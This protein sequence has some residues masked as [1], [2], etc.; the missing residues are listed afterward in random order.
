MEKKIY[1]LSFVEQEDNT[2]GSILAVIDVKSFGTNGLKEKI[3]KEVG[4]VLD[5]ENIDFDAV[6]E[7]DFNSLIDY[8]SKKVDGEFLDYE[9]YWEEVETF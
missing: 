7:D 1:L 5:I 2:K 6:S 3:K 4:Y 9:F 8:L